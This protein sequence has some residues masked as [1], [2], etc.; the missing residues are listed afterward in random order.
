VVLRATNASGESAASNSIT[1]TPT[2][3]TVYTPALLY[4]ETSYSGS[5]SNITN[6]AAGGV[7]M[8]GTKTAGVTYVTGSGLASRKV[9]DFPTG[10]S[11]N[12][13]NYN[14]GNAF[15][16]V[17]WVYPRSNGS[18]N[19]I[20]A[21]VGANQAP[22]GFKVG[23]NTWMASN[24]TMT[25]EGGNGSAGSSDNTVVNTVTLDTWQQLTFMIDKTNAFIY[26]IKNDVPATSNTD[27]IITSNIG[28]NNANFRI[29]SFTD[30]SYSMNGQIGS[31]KV[32]DR[33]LSIS[34]IAAEYQ[35]TKANYGL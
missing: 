14:F 32:Y 11:I 16:I 8:T 12:F 10:N 26:F 35:A 20:L 9:F 7:S 1:V 24:Y 13:G 30:G 5:G 18:I 28:T 15:S 17:T 22:L 34:E 2:A 19:G 21:N 31:L 23:W 29:G 3:S 27:N 4:D 6:Q 25:F 33:L